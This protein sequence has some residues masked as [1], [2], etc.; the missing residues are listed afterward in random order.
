MNIKYRQP[1]SY[2]V[3][4]TFLKIFNLYTL[5]TITHILESDSD[6][7][8]NHNY[9]NTQSK[10]GLESHNPEFKKNLG[11]HLLNGKQVSGDPL[12]SIE[13][14]EVNKSKMSISMLRY[15]NCT[16]QL[17]LKAVS[18]SCNKSFKSVIFSF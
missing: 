1:E 3:E 2:L 15:P 13:K 9:N 10:I 5:E 14:T 12:S 4:L 11:K 16:T 6:F 8:M 17:V 7:K 18:K